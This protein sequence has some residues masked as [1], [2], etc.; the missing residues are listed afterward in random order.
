NYLRIGTELEQFDRVLKVIRWS[1]DNHQQLTLIEYCL[2]QG[3]VSLIKAKLN[4]NGS[5]RYNSGA[6]WKIAEQMD[7]KGFASEAREVRQA[8]VER[9][10]ASPLD[11]Y[12]A[13][14]SARRL[15]NVDLCLTI[16]ED[17]Q[18]AYPSA[19]E[20]H[21]LYLQLCASHLEHERYFT[22]MKIVAG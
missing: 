11:A 12:F 5:G 6:L 18:R 4:L 17:G 1:P 3:H 21:N 9:P 19:T 2:D 14:A 7:R 13:A 10:R 22:F 16:L 8:I 20:L 15:G